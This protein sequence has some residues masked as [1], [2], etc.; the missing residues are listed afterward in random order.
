MTGAVVILVASVA[1]F[2]AGLAVAEE[3]CR[4]MGR[5]GGFTLM[6]IGVFGFVA[7]FVAVA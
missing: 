6:T 3:A 1:V 2:G 4:W 7:V 5:V